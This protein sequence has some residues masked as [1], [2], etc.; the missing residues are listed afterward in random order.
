MTPGESWEGQKDG[1]AM[2]VRF[3]ELTLEGG[4]L[5]AI[6]GAWICDVTGRTFG[7]TYL[8]AEGMAPEE[9]LAAFERYLE[10]LACH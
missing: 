4:T 6:S 5:P 7:V 10:G 2:A 3:S 9:L 8:T 1:H